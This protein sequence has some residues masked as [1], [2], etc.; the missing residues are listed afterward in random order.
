MKR[1][2]IMVCAACTAEIEAVI[3]ERERQDEK[4]GEQNHG[5]DGWLLILMEEVGEAAKAVLEG[6]S[7]QYISELTQ[8][9]AVAVAAMESAKR[10]NLELGSLA[11]IQ[12]EL[13]ELRK[14]KKGK[15]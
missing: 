13:N 9:A 14:A 1:A 11:K 15:P 3:R 6:S 5:P 12:K 4:W 10:G 8:V 7:L 2:Q